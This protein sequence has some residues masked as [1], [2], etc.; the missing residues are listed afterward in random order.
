[1]PFVKQQK[2]KAYFK[3]FQVKYRRRREGKTDYYQRKKLVIQA[4]NK[5][6]SPKYR[7]VVRC[8][9][10]QII[11]QIV[12][13]TIAGDKVLSSAYSKELSRY[14]LKAG[15]KNYA[16]A[17]CTG[18]LVGRRVLKKIGLF[19]KY[20]GV[21]D[22][23][24]DEVTGEIMSTTFQKKTYYVDELDDDRRPL[25]V[26]LD[27]GLARTSLGAKIFGALKGASDAGLDIPHNHKKF[28]G[29]D[30]G[31]KEYDASAHKDQIF[32]ENIS[33]YMRYLEQEDEESG[34]HRLEEQFRTYIKAG[35][36]ADD[37]EQMYLDVHKAI[38]ADPS[39]KH[40]KSK[41]ERNVGAKHNKDRKRQARKT[42]EQRD[43]DVQAKRDKIAAMQEDEESSEEE[44]DEE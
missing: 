8:T 25:R 27:I 6:A 39:P 43:A 9:G 37:L 21:G 22:D 38:R 24:E 7:L 16:A 36:T 33:E 19:D 10:T 31:E 20:T 2:P 34:T 44:E 14:G 35:V 17:Y 12:Y 29:Y 18:L 40:E 26:N 3:R 1:M 41:K 32:G 30:A 42:K 13:A 5:Y 23:E 11:C 15:F 4:K 28:P